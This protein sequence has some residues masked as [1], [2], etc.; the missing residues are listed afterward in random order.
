[1]HAGNVKGDVRGTI[2]EITKSAPQ[3]LF[4]TNKQLIS[5]T[6]QLVAQGTENDLR[7]YFC[8]RDTATKERAKLLN[9]G[10]LAG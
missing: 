1:M 4:S 3:L 7:H 9:K 6:L 10:K 5:A 8:A 2:F